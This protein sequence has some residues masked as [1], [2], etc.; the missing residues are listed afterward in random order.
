MKSPK[1][2][3]GESQGFHMKWNSYLEIFSLPQAIENYRQFLLVRKDM[4][5]EKTVVG[6]P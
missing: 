4:I 6:C 1:N 3:L 2:V 5:S